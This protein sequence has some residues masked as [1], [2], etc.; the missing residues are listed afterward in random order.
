MSRELRL[1]VSGLGSPACVCAD[2]S[3]LVFGKGLGLYALWVSIGLIA[4]VYSLSRT[5]T[6]WCKFDLAPARLAVLRIA[7]VPF[8]TSAFGQHTIVG[9]IGV[10]NG[11]LGGVTQPFI[12]KASWALMTR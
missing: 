11:V 5:T 12:A 9:T 2:I 3:D 6:F 8:A 4:Y 7:D 1:C 10:I